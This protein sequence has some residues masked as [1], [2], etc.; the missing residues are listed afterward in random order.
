MDITARI[1]RR[2]RNGD[3]PRLVRDYQ[4]LSTVPH[5]GEPGLRSTRSTSHSLRAHSVCDST[6][7]LVNF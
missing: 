3:E 1:R 5:V 4:A 7:R 6:G 2:Q